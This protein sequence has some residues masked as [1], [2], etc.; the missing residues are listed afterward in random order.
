VN[1]FFIHGPIGKQGV[2]DKVP[3]K[4]SL[5]KLMPGTPNNYLVLKAL[6]LGLYETDNTQGI[7]MP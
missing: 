2:V 7:K 6:I 1:Y 3:L 5:T 4:V